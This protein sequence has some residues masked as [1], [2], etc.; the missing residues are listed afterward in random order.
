MGPEL[1]H[2]TPGAG[3]K[4]T[5]LPAV[6]SGALVSV[7]AADMAVR[8]TRRRGHLAG[9]EDARCGSKKRRG[10]CEVQRGAG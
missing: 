3:W 7:L 6:E 8:K 1:T 2:P 5:R 4:K 10:V 9:R